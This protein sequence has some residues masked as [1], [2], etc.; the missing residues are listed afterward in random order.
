MQ[1]IDSLTSENVIIQKLRKEMTSA[2]LT[3]SLLWFEWGIVSD[4]RVR[5]VCCVVIYDLHKEMK[6]VWLEK[7]LGDVKLWGVCVWARVR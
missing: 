7:H 6:S 2:S 3:V 5:E 4:V 1:P